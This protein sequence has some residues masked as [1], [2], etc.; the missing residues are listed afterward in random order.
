MNFLCVL[1]SQTDRNRSWGP[2]LRYMKRFL[3]QFEII[4]RALH[5]GSRGPWKLPEKGNS[6][7]VVRGGCKRSFGPREQRSPKSLLH[8]PKPLF[9]T[10]AAPFCTG[11]RGLLLA[12]TDL[13]RP[14]LTTLGNVPGPWLPN[15][16]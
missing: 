4:T 16:T 9:C 12:V 3:I 13:L 15:I 5:V 2:G 10:G 14:L 8:H 6:R 11:A 7:E 1:L